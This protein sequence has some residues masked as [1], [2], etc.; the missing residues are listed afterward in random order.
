MIKKETLQGG[1]FYSLFVFVRP[2][3][4][5]NHIEDLRNSTNNTGNCFS[6]TTPF[7][8]LLNILKITLDGNVRELENALSGCHSC[9]FSVIE[10]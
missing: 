6:G 2:P 10:P 1:Y 5:K 7:V 3:S 9:Q 8:N 4:F